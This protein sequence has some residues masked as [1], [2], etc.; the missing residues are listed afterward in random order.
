[1]SNE[2]PRHPSDGLSDTAIP[3][4]GGMKAQRST[5]IDVPR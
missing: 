4:H 2:N 5:S 1:M 3:T